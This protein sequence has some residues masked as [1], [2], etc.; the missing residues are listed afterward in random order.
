[1][2][3]YGWI[4]RENR[5]DEDLINRVPLEILHEKYLNGFYQDTDV[6]DVEKQQ[7]KKLMNVIYNWREC[8]KI[9]CDGRTICGLPVSN[10][11]RDV[12]RI[13]RF[14]VTCKTCLKIMSLRR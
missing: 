9:G 4:D 2:D 12:M 10:C 11:R 13:T 5:I 1:M 8:H 14:K 3:G 7:I 6:P